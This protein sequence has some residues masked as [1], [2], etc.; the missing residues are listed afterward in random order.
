MVLHCRTHHTEL[1][2]QGEGF[3]CPEGH[4]VYSVSLREVVFEC[5]G[6]LAAP[7]GDGAYAG[8]RSAYEGAT[9]ASA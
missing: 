7:S 6:I 3:W 9:H 1:V 4:A 5:I 2:T 8:S